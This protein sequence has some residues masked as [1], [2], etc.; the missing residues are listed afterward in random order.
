[1]YN[2]GHVIFTFE[3]NLMKVNNYAKKWRCY[4][5]AFMSYHVNTHRHIDA[6]KQFS[7]S[8]LQSVTRKPVGFYLSSNMHKYYAFSNHIYTFSFVPLMYSLFGRHISF[9]LFRRNKQRSTN[10]WTNY[11]LWQSFLIFIAYIEN[12]YVYLIAQLPIVQLC[13]PCWFTWPLF[14]L[15]DLIGLSRPHDLILLAMQ[16]STSLSPSGGII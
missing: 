14:I 9:S 4:I 2:I 13:L 3:L 6:S 10:C 12:F 1:M 16:F 7:P 5:K 15:N 11:I 8:L